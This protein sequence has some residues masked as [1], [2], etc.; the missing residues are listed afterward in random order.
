MASV[1]RKF[2]PCRLCMPWRDTTNK[3][4]CGIYVM[5]HMESYMGGGTKGW[6]CGLEK[7]NASQLSNLRTKYSAAIILHHSNELKDRSLISLVSLSRCDLLTKAST[8][9]LTIDLI[10]RDSPQSPSYDPSLS[11][12]QRVVNALRRSFNRAQRFKLN[13]SI[14]SRKSE[15][16]GS[17]GEYLMKYSIGTP[18]VSS[19]GIV[20]TSSD[21]TW[22]QCQP[23][24][25][26]FNQNLPLFNPKKSSTYRTIRCNTSECNSVQGTSCSRTRKNCLYLETFSD[27]S[28]THGLLSTDTF[29]LASS[30]GKRVISAPNIVFGCGFRNTISFGSGGSGIV[31]LGGGNSSLVTQLGSLARGKFSYCLVLLSDN[32]KKSSKLNFGT[33]AEVLGRGVVSTP[34]VRTYPET[35]YYL[36]L[37]GISVGNQ[38]L[39]FYDN[40]NSSNFNQEGNIIIDSGIT[41]TLLPTDFYNKLKKALQSSIKLEQIK[42]PKGVLDLCFVSRKDIQVPKITVHFQFADVELK[43]ENVFVRTSDVAVCLAVKPVDLIFPVYGSIAQANFLVGYDLVQR[44]VSFKA[45]R[46][47]KK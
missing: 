5:R 18:P 47:G 20:D 28:F 21:I 7:N 23:C 12:S 30:S 46:C 22:T 44:T 34:I 16:I 10:H 41:L 8:N 4:D 1:V 19:L 36:T 6:D 29:T 26:C 24:L 31:G 32:S 45:T 27:E 33:N 17:N 37:E 3:V 35:Y 43:T 25:K 39:E 14:Q 2:T 9:G 15:I 11:S 42:D 40:A 38:K 13:R